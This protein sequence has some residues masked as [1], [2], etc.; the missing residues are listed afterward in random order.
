MKLLS[1]ILVFILSIATQAASV[2]VEKFDLDFY[3]DE[4]KYEIDFSLEMACRYEKFVISDS[5]EYEYITREVP[6]TIKK[7]KITNTETLVTI[8]NKNKAFLKLDGIFRSN[9]QCQT[10]LNFF[11]KSKIYSIGWANQYH[12]PIRL[13]VFEHSRLEAYKVFDIDALKDIFEDKK[14]SFNYKE[15]SVQFN[16]RLAFDGVSTTGTSTYLSTSVAKDPK[17]S[18]PYKLKK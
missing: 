15:S 7:K 17:T 4:T 8:S 11:I 6:L 5:S 2:T 9:K 16:V 18:R 12:R 14:V 10:Y 3:L 13:G 1:L